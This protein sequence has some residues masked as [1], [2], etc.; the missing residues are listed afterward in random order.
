MASWVWTHFKGVGSKARCLVVNEDGKEYG[1]ELVAKYSTT[2]L[3][4]HLT[5]VHGIK[6]GEPTQRKK[7]IEFGGPISSAI[8]MNANE[9]ICATW[10]CNGLSCDLI[11]DSLFRRAFCMA[12]PMGLNRIQLSNT[13]V[14]FSGMLM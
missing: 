9:V 8:T 4:Y 1:V 3:S 11:D 5:E 13:M 12:I 7:R 10:A 14:Q 2:P 6:K